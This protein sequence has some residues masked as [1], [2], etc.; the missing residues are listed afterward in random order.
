MPLDPTSPHLATTHSQEFA[1]AGFSYTRTGMICRHTGQGTSL[2]TGKEVKLL[3]MC[4]ICVARVFSQQGFNVVFTIT[5]KL[6]I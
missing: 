1:S 2:I 5:V 6:Q 3:R 4:L